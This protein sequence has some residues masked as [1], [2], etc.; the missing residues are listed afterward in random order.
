MFVTIGN[1]IYSPI[2]DVIEKKGV[3]GVVPTPVGQ[4]LTVVIEP[5]AP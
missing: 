2:E 1:G 3:R 5:T 4:H